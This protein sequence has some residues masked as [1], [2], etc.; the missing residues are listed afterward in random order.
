V[1]KLWKSFGI[2]GIIEEDSSILCKLPNFGS[3]KTLINS[4]NYLK[5]PAG[6]DFWGSFG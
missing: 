3:I 2:E 5:T 6:I 1:K 4:I